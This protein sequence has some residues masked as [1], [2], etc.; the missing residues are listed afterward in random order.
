MQAEALA[1]NSEIIKQV[2]SS[3]SIFIHSLHKFEKWYQFS[4]RIKARSHK[5]R[6]A[7]S[8]F[9]VSSGLVNPEDGDTMIP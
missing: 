3:L 2:T 4:R 1:V 8:T 6:P 5:K 9:L 7:Y